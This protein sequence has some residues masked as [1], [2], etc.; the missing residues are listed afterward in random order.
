MPTWVAG[1]PTTTPLL[2]MAI[3]PKNRPI[4]AAMAE[5]NDLGMPAIIQVRAPLTVSKTKITP[6]INTAPSACC[7]VKPNA[8]TTV[9]A[10]NALR[11]MPGAIPMGQLATK[12]MVKVPTT[13]AK[14]VATNTAPRSMPV[15]ERM[16]GLTKMM[17]DMVKKVVMPRSEER[18]VGK[19]SRQRRVAEQAEIRRKN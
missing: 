10:K 1:L 8:P 11:P 4:P 16:S 15:L 6:E 14:Q 17:Y 18:R 3:R 2:I 5:R 12:A 19:E 13:A 7:Q 9:K